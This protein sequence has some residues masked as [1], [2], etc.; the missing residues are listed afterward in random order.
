MPAT[1]PDPERAALLLRTE[2][3]AHRMAKADLRKAESNDVGRAIDRARQLRG[4]SL[5]EFSGAAQREERQIARWIAG[6]EHP[7][8]DTL[9]AIVSFRHALIVALAESAGLGV[10][11]HTIVTIEQAPA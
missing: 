4:W 1:V 6:T 5:K 3:R 10:K 11:V 9:F 2:N 8:L 7:Q